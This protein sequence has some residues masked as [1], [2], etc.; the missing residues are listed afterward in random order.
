MRAD[1]I[2]SSYP[3][4]LAF[5][6]LLEDGRLPE[7]G[8]EELTDGIC[9]GIGAVLPSFAG[10]LEQTADTMVKRI[11]ARGV[12]CLNEAME[13]RDFSMTEITLRRLEREWAWSRYFRFLRFLPEELREE[14]DL[15]VL[16]EQ[17]RFRR[18]LLQ[19]L[20]DAADE[21]GDPELFDLLYAVRRMWGEHG[22][23]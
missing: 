3:E 4:W 13:N 8:P 12:R 5:L 14:L 20:A 7:Y 2:P 17:Q 21:T 18:E 10:R 19:W 9:P 6:Q 23:L 22:E 15:A 11:A 1:R 16:R